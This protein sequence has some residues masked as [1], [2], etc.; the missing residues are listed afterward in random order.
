[1]DDNTRD[2]AD[3]SFI[4]KWP[5]WLRW[6]LFLPASFIM[7]VVASVPYL[8]MV[9][10]SGFMFGFSSGGFFYQLISSCILGGGFVYAGSWVAPKHQFEI[11]LF[12]LVLLSAMG[13]FVFLFS[14]DEA[15]LQGPW[16]AG[17]HMLMV[18][19][20]GIWAVHGIKNT[21]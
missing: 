10:I 17:V 9:N 14:F 21:H 6:V 12:L 15:S 19:G 13:T 7:A 2:I 1:M 5:T 20:A 11:S 8:L 4:T 18:I 3:G 16:T